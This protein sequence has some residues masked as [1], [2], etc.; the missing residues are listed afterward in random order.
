MDFGEAVAQTVRDQ[1]AAAFDQAEADLDAVAASIAGGFS[2]YRDVLG[3]EGQ[4]P[5][6]LVGLDAPTGETR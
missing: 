2:A 3:G 1:S 6:R 5:A 4:K